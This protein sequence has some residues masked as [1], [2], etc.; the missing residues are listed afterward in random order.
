MDFLAAIMENEDFKTGNTLTSF[1]KTFHFA[2]AAIDVISAGACKF[3]PPPN[4]E[5]APDSQQILLCKTSMADPASAKG[6]RT[7]ARWT[8]SP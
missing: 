7:L 2:P 1:L 3:A 8:R 4:G 5:M 6:S